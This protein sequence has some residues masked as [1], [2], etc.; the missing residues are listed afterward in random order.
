MLGNRGK[1]MN[2]GRVRPSNSIDLGRKRPDPDSLRFSAAQRRAASDPP[3]ALPMHGWRSKIVNTKP[4]LAWLGLGGL[5]SDRR[6]RVI[7]C[8]YERRCVAA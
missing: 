4:R 5:I 6:P 1:S 7:T 8:E 3:M 2:S